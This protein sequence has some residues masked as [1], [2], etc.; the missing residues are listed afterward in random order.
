M[1]NPAQPE[2]CT[3]LLQQLAPQPAAVQEGETLPSTTPQ[4]DI[5]QAVPLPNDIRLQIEQEQTLA[6]A[7]K[8]VRELEEQVGKLSTEKEGVVGER[9]GAGRFMFY[10]LFVCQT[11]QEQTD[12]VLISGCIK[13]ATHAAFKSSIIP[14][15]N[16]FRTFS[17]ADAFRL[18]RK[19]KEGI[20]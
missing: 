11:S 14:S 16:H 5:T 9:D 7:Q 13:S 12:D 20:I 2:Q 8:R 18:D 4:T 3:Q 6:D 15:Q 19:G 1:D 17:V 10:S